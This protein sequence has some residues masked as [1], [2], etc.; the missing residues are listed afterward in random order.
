MDL[1]EE[2]C[3]LG[4]GDEVGGQYFTPPQLSIQIDTVPMLNIHLKAHK[5]RAVPDERPQMAGTRAQKDEVLKLEMNLTAQEWER[6]Q[7]NWVRYKCY[8]RLTDQGDCV[9]N[10]WACFSRDLKVAAADNDW[11]MKHS[12]KIRSSSRYLYRPSGAPTPWCLKSSQD[13]WLPSKVKVDSESYTRHTQARNMCALA[14]SEA[15][16]VMMGPTHS[17]MLGIKEKEYLPA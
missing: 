14:D 3:V 4:E 12:M 5:L 16:M 17:A 11:L 10:L 13:V 8:T 6:W 9:Y 7:S 2:T 15:Q 1:M